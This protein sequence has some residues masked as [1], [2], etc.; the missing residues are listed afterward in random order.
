M[1]ML[2]NSHRLL[3]VPTPNLLHLFCSSV[4]VHYF[5][6]LTESHR[7]LMSCKQRRNRKEMSHVNFFLAL[8]FYPWG[9]YQE[10]QNFQPMS[11]FALIPQKY[12]I[13]QECQKILLLGSLLLVA[14][15]SSLQTSLYYSPH[16]VDAYTCL[17]A[18]R[19]A[20]T[21]AHKPA[22]LD[23]CRSTAMIRYYSTS[24]DISCIAG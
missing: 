12:I 9:R 4:R 24:S 6:N 11:C 20:L 8:P 21:A 22:E 18:Y 15:V 16:A 7:N 1:S 17:A 5:N 3:R 23:I 14:S 19:T 10:E 13:L 2:Q